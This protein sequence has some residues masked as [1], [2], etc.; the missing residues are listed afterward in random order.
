MFLVGKRRVAVPEN[1]ASVTTIDTEA[2]QDPRLVGLTSAGIEQMWSS[3]E[4]LYRSELHPSVT[5]LVRRRGQ[6]VLKRAIGHLSGVTPED[7]DEPVLIHP[8]A[9]QNLFSASKAV[10]ALLIHKLVDEG[11]L[12]LDD[13]VCRYVPEFA[14]QGK[15][16]ITLRDV[17][18]HRAGVP[19]IPPEH[20][21]PDLLLDWDEVVR[22]I[23][24]EPPNDKGKRRQAY[25]A[26]TAGF[27][28]GEVVRRVGDIELR[29]ALKSW[30]A[31]PLGCEYLTFGADKDI[32]HL[33][34]K[35]VV[36]GQKIL[37]PITKYMERV[38]AI[39]FEDAVHESNQDAFL[40]AIAPAGNV[41]ASADDISKVFE[42]MRNQGQYNGQQILK[43]ETVAA[44]IAPVSKLK[45]D[46]TLLLPM[47]YSAGFMLGEDPWSLLGP[48]SGDSFGHLGFLNILCWADPRREIS[49]SLM[50]TGK[51]FAGPGVAGFL[52]AIF[53]I[54]KVCE[55]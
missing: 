3:V 16:H 11:R 42:M 39:P 33:V 34:P 31:D 40:S 46:G 1:L 35:N 25:H 17:L 4:T 43:P 36:T 18:T 21:N 10:T 29:D 44:A 24:A 51:T 7:H 54:N 55:Q 13:P 50:N 14:A 15:A 53:T 9:P 26:L 12:S 32:R 28:A 27:I 2:E 6:I 30:L 37:W 19:Y 23:C 5:L 8:D 48:K 38:A 22:L 41:H 20:A 47:R 52:K 45:I 49:V